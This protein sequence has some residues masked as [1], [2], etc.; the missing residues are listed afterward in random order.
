MNASV[1]NPLQLTTWFCVH[2]LLILF[3]DICDVIARCYAAVACNEVP[4]DDNCLLSLQNRIL[5]TILCK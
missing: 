5:C 2:I 1:T 3:V 4:E